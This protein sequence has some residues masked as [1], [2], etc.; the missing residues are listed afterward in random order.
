MT[1]TMT[2]FG[3]IPHLHL[4]LFAM[5]RLL[6]ASWHIRDTHSHTIIDFNPG[7]L[8]STFS[9]SGGNVK[10]KGNSSPRCLIR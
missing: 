4:L 8:L 5:G 2:I 10:Q 1:L 9:S 6:R 7:L 3:M